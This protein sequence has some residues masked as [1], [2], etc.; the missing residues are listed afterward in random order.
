MNPVATIT[1]NNNVK[2]VVELYPELAPNTINSFIYLANQG[3]FDNWPFA[4]VEPG[5]V[6]DAS[7]NAFNREVCRYLIANEAAL[8]EKD[9]RLKPE[10]GVM[11]MGGYDGHIAS[12]EFFFPLAHH[13]RLDGHYPMV[14][15]VIEGLEEIERLGKVPVRDFRYNHNTSKPLRKPVTDEVIT[16]VRVETFGV[17]YPEP[18]RLE[19]VA[20]PDHWLD[21]NYLE[22]V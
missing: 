1:I 11:G 19:G 5:F 14:G 22:L 20:L 9:K 15:R 18:K 4:R 17:E 21:E 8:V 3:A 12:G 7:T 6:V 2:V 16:S 13:E 10:F